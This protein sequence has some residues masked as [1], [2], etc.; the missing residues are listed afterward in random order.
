MN[1][2]YEQIDHMISE[3]RKILGDPYWNGGG[4]V[5]ARTQDQCR[6]FA[7]FVGGLGACSDCGH[8]VSW[9]KAKP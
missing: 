9:H 2:N 8:P 6:P 4:A 1:D 7:R 3:G 5:C